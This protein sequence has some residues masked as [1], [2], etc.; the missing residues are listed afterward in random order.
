[1]KETIHRL[2]RALP[3]RGG[4]Q[5]ARAAPIS[6]LKVF[7]IRAALAARIGN[8]LPTL[9]TY[10]GVWHTWFG[11]DSA[12]V[13]ILGLLFALAGLRVLAGRE[14]RLLA[15]AGLGLAA[16]LAGIY[17]S[18]PAW[19]HN[20]LTFGRYML[21]GQPLLLLCVALGMA[22]LLHRVSQ[23]AL[24][25]AGAVLLPAL[26]LIGTPH[27]DLLR[28]PNNFSLHYWY[29]FDYRR[30][31][32]PVR[33]MGHLPVSPFWSGFADVAPGSLRIAVAG[34]GLESYTI[35]DVYWQQ[36]HRQQVVSAQLW[37]YCGRPPYYGE[38]LPRHGFFLHNA[39]TLADSSDLVRKRIDYVVFD[40]KGAR[41]VESCIARFR[42]EH[43]A[44]AYED[45][46]LVAF[47]LN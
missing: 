20:A 15:M 45:D 23:P 5:S 12:A 14:P 46:R 10:V 11:T 42:N 1:M 33:E 35:Y 18:R 28:R 38:A 6:R 44:P 9:D 30:S 8:D 22:G 16:T 34:H 43:G 21:P 26:F 25:G 7:L 24:R 47:R 29:Q 4:P 27:A 41:E 40:R 17:L 31:H 32:N 3:P 39:V 2:T 37:G 13:V 36:K 19:V